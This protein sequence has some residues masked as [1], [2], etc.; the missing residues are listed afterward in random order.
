[1]EVWREGRK[2]Q[3]TAQL[4]RSGDK[5]AAAALPD[6]GEGGR[7][8]LALRPLEPEEKAQAGLRGGVVVEDVAGPAEAAGVEPGDVVLAV[9]GTPV[10]TPQQVQAAVAR[11]GRS[12]ALLIQRGDDRIFVPV[13]IG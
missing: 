1:M 13:R 7:V 5:V 9:N 3:L 8:G 2:V 10:N 12:V 11:S 6:T 4:A